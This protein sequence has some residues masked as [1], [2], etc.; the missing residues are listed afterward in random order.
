[1]S[2]ADFR[3]MLAEVA[4][5]SPVGQELCRLRPGSD[6]WADRVDRAAAI[7]LLLLWANAPESHQ[8]LA[9]ALI[10]GGCRDSR[11]IIDTVAATLADP[12]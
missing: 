10:R 1:V 8:R 2:A 4:D 6:D 12:A 9:V 11:V 3:R 5:L 7:E